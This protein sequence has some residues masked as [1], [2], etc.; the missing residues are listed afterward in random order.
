[1]LTITDSTIRSYIF[2]HILNYSQQ[3]ISYFQLK[4]SHQYI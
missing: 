2:L 4:G 3:I 1:M